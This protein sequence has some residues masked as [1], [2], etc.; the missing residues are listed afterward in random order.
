MCVVVNFTSPVVKQSLKVE[1]PMQSSTMVN[2]YNR[3][4]QTAPTGAEKKVLSP[5]NE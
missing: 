3:F 5:I 2:D 1:Y 4:S